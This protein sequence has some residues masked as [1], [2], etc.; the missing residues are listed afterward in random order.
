MMDDAKTNGNAALRVSGI[1]FGDLLNTLVYNYL[2]WCDQRLHN[3]FRSMDNGNTGKIRTQQLR[4]KLKQID[5][6]GERVRA[7]QMID[8]LAMDGGGVID[9][10]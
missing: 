5:R 7:F 1:Q 9:V 4:D 8:A 10:R 3:A 6:L 2:V